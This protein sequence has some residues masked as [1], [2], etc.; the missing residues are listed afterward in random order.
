M[1]PFQETVA[2]KQFWQNLSWKD[3]EFSLI[4][5]ADLPCRL[6]AA[7]LGFLFQKIWKICSE[8]AI[9]QFRIPHPHHDS[10]LKDIGYV[11]ALLPESF[12]QLDSRTSTTGLA[13]QLGVQFETL[14][15]GFLLDPQ[16]QQALDEKKVTLEEIQTHAKHALNVIECFEIKLKCKKSLHSEIKNTEIKVPFLDEPMKRQLLEQMQN[17]VTKGDLKNAELI[18]QILDKQFTAENKMNEGRA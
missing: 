7:N 3:G 15:I 10:F 18:R 17:Y 16:W 14:D 11:R 6:N 12:A 1:S 2:D 5:L 4:D 9:V 13:Q 8:D